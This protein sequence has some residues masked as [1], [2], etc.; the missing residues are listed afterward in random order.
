MRKESYSTIRHGETGGHSRSEKDYVGL[1]AE[2]P[3]GFLRNKRRVQ[4]GRIHHLK[5][6]RREQNGKLNEEREKITGRLTWAK[7]EK[8]GRKKSTMSKHLG[9]GAQLHCATNL[10]RLLTK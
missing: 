6:Q 8:K 9:G 3:R 4:G 2:R 10:S 1:W 5:N 7:I